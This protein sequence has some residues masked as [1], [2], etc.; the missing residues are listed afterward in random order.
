M[1]NTLY[2]KVFRC[3]Y[4]NETTFLSLADQA[5]IVED[6]CSIPDGYGLYLL[7]MDSMPKKMT[8]RNSFS[9]PENC[10]SGS[11]V[12]LTEDNKIH[13]LSTSDRKE[14]TLFVTGQCN[15][16]CI[17][18]PYSEQYRLNAKHETFSLLNRYIDLMDPDADYLCITGGEPTIIGEDF[19]RLT[20]HVK[21]HFNSPV[22]HVLTNGR[23]FSYKSFLES[24]LS[25]RPYMTLLG[26]PLH[27]DNASLHD[28]ISQTPGS[29]QETIQG[30]DNLYYACE[31]IEIRIVTSA[32]NYH[33]LSNLARMIVDKYPYCQHVCMMGLEMMGNAMLHRKDIWCN[34]E[35]LW[36]Y[37]RE[38][39]RILVNAGIEVQLYNYP[40]CMIDENL[41]SLYKKSITPSK[42]E[43]LAECDTCHRKI[44]CGGFFR[45]TIVMPDIKVRPY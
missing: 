4:E 31:R 9:L 33:N 36:P 5:L 39:T 7:P 11:F 14:R 24:F 8:P 34:Y 19:L 29:F 32:L 42:I 26:V 12:M 20:Q 15:S 30:L 18:C 16:N 43:F 3:S 13:L 44:L 27:A 38:A 6:I 1:E 2:P 45:T 28:Y 40:L 17:M 10:D 41:Q 23:A 21:S 22:L 35:M 37:V 25:I